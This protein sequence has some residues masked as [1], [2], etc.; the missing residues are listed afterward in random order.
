[1]YVTLPQNLAIGET[2]EYGRFGTITLTNGRLDTPTA[3]VEP[4][5]AAN[6]LAAA[7][8]EN[9]ITLDDGRGT[10]NPDPAI[11]PDGEVFT[12]AHSF[13]SG[14]LVQNAIGVLDYRFSTWGVQPTDGADFTVANARPALP[15][16]GG[17]PDDLELQRAELLHVAR[18]DPD[19]L[20]TTTTTSAAQTPRRSS[21]A[22]RTRSSRRSPR[23]TPT[24]SASSRSRTTA[25]RCRRSPTH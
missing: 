11:H 8:L 15:D 5:A 9:S 10:Q 20:G 12:L 1:M 6:A 7:N 25:R 23:S 18:P 14:D 16:V 22:S 2:F 17:R 24:C 3:V 19:E 4:G 13:R 21:S